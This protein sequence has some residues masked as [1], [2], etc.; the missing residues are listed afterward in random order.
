MCSAKL[1]L[2]VE[3]DKRQREMIEKFLR[4][5]DFMVLTAA[6]GREG[7]E[8][9]K[10]NLPNLIIM[11]YVMPEMDGLTTLRILKQN[12]TTKDIPVIMISGDDINP[13]GCSFLKKPFSFSD[14]KVIL[15][16]LNREYSI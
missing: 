9:A 16:V 11:D 7:M 6:T 13:L 1:I 15:D 5:N 4:K 10:S 8:L 14:L 3:D 12:K 2:V